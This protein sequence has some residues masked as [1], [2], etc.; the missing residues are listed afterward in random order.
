MTK[1]LFFFCWVALYSTVSITSASPLPAA[2]FPVLHGF[3]RFTVNLHHSVGYQLRTPAFSDYAFKIRSISIPQGTTID[4][5]GDHIKFP[6]GTVLT[7]SFYYHS[8]PGKSCFTAQGKLQGVKIDQRFNESAPPQSELCPIE[9]RTLTKTHA[10]WKANAYLWQ[11]GSPT[12]APYGADISVQLVDLANSGGLEFQYHVP[13]K[14]QCRQCHQGNA[15]NQPDLAPIGPTRLSRL[16]LAQFTSPQWFAIVPTNNPQPTAAIEKDESLNNAA[17][18]YLDINCAHCHN[19]N[20]VAASSALFLAMAETRL[21]NLGICKRPI[22][23]GGNTFGKIYDIHPGH[24]E[25]S[26]LIDRLK[27]LENTVKMPEISKA[28]VDPSGIRLISQ[29]IKQ[30]PGSCK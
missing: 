20:G 6:T 21:Q 29:W 23:T 16:D 4:T 13:D 1:Y 22:A 17:R 7:K 27:S 25:K 2:G 30:L 15:V 9:T 3:D 18:N 14:N 24:P 19:P 28:T 8:L 10:D 11:D 5:D 26:F 12:P